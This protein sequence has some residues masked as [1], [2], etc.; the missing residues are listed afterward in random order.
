LITGTVLSVE[1][2]SLHDGPGLR[3]TVFLKGCPLFCLW[4]HNPESQSFS[5]QLYT[6]DEKCV[7]CGKCQA[8]CKNHRINADKN[9]IKSGEHIISREDCK[10]CGKCVEVCPWS[11]LEIKGSIMPADEI[12]EVV[13]KDKRYY[14]KSGGGVT[15]SGG[16]P[17]AQFS[18]ASEI[19]CL[20]KENNIH[21]CIETSGYA[22][23]A[24]FLSIMQYT[25]LFL[26]DFK[27]T[28]ED[29][30]T[31][32][33]GV[34]QGE[35]IKNLFALD[36]AGA[37]IILRCPVIPG[38]NDR[39]EFFEAISNTANKLKNIL[40]INVMP[41]HPMGSSKSKRIGRLYPLPDIGFPEDEQ[42]NEWVKNISK[43]TDI[44][45]KKG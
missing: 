23:T 22:K 12:V 28:G 4:C 11:A 38:F 1:R 34:G 17:M 5:P 14:E 30:H 45:V 44:N 20:S 8:V 36:T 18:F 41:Y 16:E 42:V 40:E 7:F 6:L 27:Q 32:H 24:Q 37:K 26:F 31:K 13:L 21:T 3:T 9:D 35:I 10:A 39:E 43:K 2:C 29:L 25:D 15:V 33:T 19:L